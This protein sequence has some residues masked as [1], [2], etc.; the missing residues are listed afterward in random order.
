MTVTFHAGL[1]SSLLAAS[2]KSSNGDQ[3]TAKVEA[4]FLQTTMRT[5][6]SNVN[7]ALRIAKHWQNLAVRMVYESKILDK[8]TKFKFYRNLLYADEEGKDVKFGKNGASKFHQWFLKGVFGTSRK[9]KPNVNQQ[10]LTSSS[11]VGEEDPFEGFGA[12]GHVSD[13]VKT[14]SA[15]PGDPFLD[16]L[17]NLYKEN[18]VIGNIILASRKLWYQGF[19]GRWDGL[20]QLPSSFLLTPIIEETGREMDTET[21]H[22]ITAN[23]L[24]YQCRY[25]AHYLKEV[26]ETN[27]ELSKDSTAELFC[28]LIDMLPLIGRPDLAKLRNKFGV[29][30]SPRLQ[31]FI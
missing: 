23:F 31:H 17:R 15:F 16:D 28:H 8:K 24:S 18:E 12:N 30:K 4:G 26:D 11:S 3:E 9:W 19:E 27:P 1:Y 21:A 25:V 14:L 5:I 13:P 20:P 6:V 2:M 7:T 29:D 10:S 22:N